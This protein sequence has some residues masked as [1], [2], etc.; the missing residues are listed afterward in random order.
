MRKRSSGGWKF[1]AAGIAAWAA[2]SFVRRRRF[3]YRGKTVLITGGSRG[4]GLILARY[5]ADAGARIAICARDSSELDRAFDELARRG[6]RVVAATCDLTERANVEELV[7]IVEGRL[8]PIDVLINNA[9]IIVVGPIGA[10]D[11]DDFE[12]SMRCNFFSA[13]HT[14]MAVLPSMRARRRGRIVNIA[15]IGGKLSLPHLLP[16]GASKFALVGLSEGLRTELA[17]DGVTVTTVCPGLMRTGSPRQ[18]IMKGRVREEFAWFSGSDAMPVLSM[19]A[20]RAARQ[21]LSAAARGDAEVVL[22]LPAKFATALQ[23]IAPGLMSRLLEWTNRALP[24]ENGNGN[25]GVKG[26]WIEPQ[27]PKWLAARNRQAALENNEI[28]PDE[29]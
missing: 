29:E 22:S 7:T 6:G 23:G 18:A 3:N 9:G 8:G 2:Y 10:L 21:I 28:D 11:L 5:L 25:A 20:E 1:L 12:R 15:S 24:G 14:I 27:G 16:Y 4:L 13:L 17:K 19:S 26:A